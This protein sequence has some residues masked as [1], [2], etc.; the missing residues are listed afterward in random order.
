MMITKKPY[1]KK[2]EKVPTTWGVGSP[3]LDYR[4]CIGGS[5]SEG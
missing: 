1:S 5:D 2:G 4:G 3:W